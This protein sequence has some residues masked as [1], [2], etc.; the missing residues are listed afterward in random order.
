MI[1][2]S[3]KRIVTALASFVTL[4]AFSLSHAEVPAPITSSELNTQVSGPIAVGGKTQFNITGGTRPGGASGTNLFH[5][6]GDLSVPTNNIANFLNAGSIDLNGNVLAPNLPTSNILG[7][8][9]GGNPSAIFGAI[10]TTNFGN[11]NLFLMNPAGFLFGPNATV[12]VGGMVAFTTADYLRLSNGVLFNNTPNVAQDALLSAAP[13]AAFGFLGSNAAAIAIQG[14]TLQVAQGQSLFFVGGNQG[15]T[16]ME[17]E[18]S[19]TISVPGGV[20]MTGAK[21]SAP[22]GQI[23]L[24]SVASPGEILLAGLQ[25]ASNINGQ[26]FTTMGNITLSQGATLNVSGNAAGTVRIRGGQ[27]ELLN[28]SVNADTGEANGAE[29]AIDVRVTGDLSIS[30]DS[31]SAFTARALGSGNAGEIRLDSAKMDVDFAF[32]EFVGVVIDSSTVG[33]GNA[34]KVTVTTGDLTAANNNT[35]EF[36]NVFIDSGTG[37]KGNGGDVTI[38]VRNGDFLGAGINTGDSFFFGTGSA[39][40]LYIGGANGMADSLHI[41]A[42]GLSTEAFSAIAGAI[43][44]E[45][46]DISITNN[47]FVS[48]ISLLGENPITINADQLS[49]DTVIR[50]Q[51]QTRGPG[52]GGDIVFTGKRLEMRNESAFITNTLG[53]GNAG[54]IRV[55]ASEYVRFSDNPLVTTPSGLFT[56]STGSEGVTTSGNAGSIHVITPRLE[57]TGGAR[58]STTTQTAGRGGDATVTASEGV[59]ISGQ[60]L[61][62]PLENFGLGG[63]DGSG[64][65]TRTIGTEQCGAACGRGGDQVITTGR[66]ILQN[67]G[68]LDSGT[69]GNG[70]GGDIRIIA[71][72]DVLLTGTLTDG[73]TPS[74]IFSRTIGT[75]SDS[76]SGGNIA[77]TAG[78]SVTISDG[79]SVSASSTGPGNAGNISINAGQQLDMRDSSIKTGAELASGGDINIRAIDRVRLVNS[80]INTSVFGEDGNGG[81]ITIDPNVVVLQG[82]QVKAEAFQGVGGDITITTP[83][84]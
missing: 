15:F 77:L 59:F 62:G 11:A 65:F 80:S 19:N 25:F 81:N 16:Y 4:L 23:N 41:D 2:P 74:G 53:N 21:L 43:T 31:V 18:T 24:A 71:S 73:T 7:R 5:S 63:S 54:N 70:N 58:I 76:G 22:G 20:T 17:P 64:I 79:A 51:A 12:N 49:M 33:S 1:A 28:S 3:Q 47:T 83:L 66:L 29:T 67:G 13:V 10:Q 32:S 78:Q 26:S 6:F 27:F 82:S 68:I 61:G 39:G 46:H 9:T 69:T 44:L 45:A 30:S 14:S 50:V 72:Q 36:V 35:T 34:G 40:N 48:S 55:N 84:F 52:N 57:M 38:K 37:G 56:N 42:A 8:V 60:R 75:T